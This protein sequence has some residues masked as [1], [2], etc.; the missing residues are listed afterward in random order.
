MPTNDPGR[1]SRAIPAMLLVLLAG[2]GPASGT[3]GS[4]S[5]LGTD[6]APLPAA[7]LV[8]GDLPKLLEPLAPVVAASGPTNTFVDIRYHANGLSTSWVFFVPTVMGN[9]GFESSSTFLGSDL[10]ADVIL[11]PLPRFSPPGSEVVGFG[12][13]DI[14]L[15][16]RL[17]PV[18]GS[19]VKISI[20][21]S[22]FPTASTCAFTVRITDSVVTGGSRITDLL[23]S[24]GRYMFSSSDDVNVVAQLKSSIGAGDPLGITV[25]LNT[26]PV[27]GAPPTQ[28]AS[29]SL[30]AGRILQVS[31]KAYAATFAF[32][33]VPSSLKVK[34]VDS[35]SYQRYD[36]DH[37]SNTLSGAVTLQGLGTLT[38]TNAPKHVDVTIQKQTWTEAKLCGSAVN[39]LK[40]FAV[41]AGNAPSSGSTVTF[42]GKV[43]DMNLFVDIRRLTG[44]GLNLNLK[45]TVHTAALSFANQDGFVDV[46]IAGF[47]FDIERCVQVPV[48]IHA[49]GSGL[50]RLQLTI[51]AG[52][53]VIDLRA[54]DSR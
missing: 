44:L 7:E 1:T 20:Q 22:P 3:I 45:D 28:T 11:T 18:A 12:Y 54:R 6:D 34:I 2:T 27:F 26:C 10:Y 13:N 25:T 52:L 21:V 48:E 8:A 49:D 37:D 40:S 42:S 16:V 33:G 5:G 51:R 39:D 19:P 4:G 15:G 9:Y 50:G 47:V 23:F 14:N 29:L 36:L 17:N 53:P 46:D 31:G 32:T 38:V 30:P 35:G 41:N 24:K 43:K